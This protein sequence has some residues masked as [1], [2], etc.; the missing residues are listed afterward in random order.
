MKRNRIL[1][2]M[3][4]CGMVLSGITIQS[5]QTVSAGNFTRAS[6]HDPSIVK[7]QDGSY[8]IIGSHLGA[9]RSSDLMNRQCQIR[10]IAPPA[11]PCNVWRLYVCGLISGF[12]DCSFTG[13]TSMWSMTA[14]IISPVCPDQHRPC[15]CRAGECHSG[16]RRV[17]RRDVACG[18]GQSVHS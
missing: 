13:T 6:V 8:Y 9:A 10:I 1:P 14:L 16:T 17:F 4:A 7:L 12:M 3:L 2:A 15:H 18:S 5:A 11:P